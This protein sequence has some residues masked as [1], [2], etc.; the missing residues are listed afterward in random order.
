MLNLRLMRDIVMVEKLEAKSGF[1]ILPEDSRNYRLGKVVNLGP[2]K[3]TKTGRSPIDMNV[4]DT[5][6][7]G[8]DIGEVTKVDGKQFLIIKEED[9]MGVVE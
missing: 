1:I 2:G 6:I 5:V 7:F 4:G 9:I 8:D 3:K